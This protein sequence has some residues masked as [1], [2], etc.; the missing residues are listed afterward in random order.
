MNETNNQIQVKSQSLDQILFSELEKNE[1]IRKIIKQWH[2]PDREGSPSMTTLVYEGFNNKEGKKVSKEINFYQL[3]DPYY[4]FTDKEATISHYSQHN[5][6]KLY[7]SIIDLADRLF[8]QGNFF[9]EWYEM[10]NQ[11]YKQESA[12]FRDLI[13]NDNVYSLFQAVYTI[14]SKNKEKNLLWLLDKVVNLIKTRDKIYKEIKPYT[15][16]TDEEGRHIIEVGK[17]K[18]QG[19]IF[20]KLVDGLDNVVRIAYK[21]LKN[22]GLVEEEINI[23]PKD[24]IGKYYYH[25][26][27]GEIIEGVWFETIFY[28]D[29]ADKAAEVITKFYNNLKA[30]YESKEVKN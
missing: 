4:G 26:N 13:L 17:G 18:M 20:W 14:D 29:Y 12:Y 5:K 7:A 22:L 16:V 10:P 1:E 3:G 15:I 27:Y 28:K 23:S 30:K 2:G 25:S 24:Y 11:E 19:F 8:P 6:K 9:E 21:S